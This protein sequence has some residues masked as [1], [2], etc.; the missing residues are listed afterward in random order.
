MK[1]INIIY[2]NL[3]ML[4]YQLFHIYKGNVPEKLSFASY[5]KQD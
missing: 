4:L 1:Y 2:P 5:E 3:G